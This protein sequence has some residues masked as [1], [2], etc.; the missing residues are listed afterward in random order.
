[1]RGDKIGLVGPNG[2]G[3]TTLAKIITDAEKFQN[4][5]KKFGHMVEMEYYSQHQADTMELNKTVYEI[6]ENTASGDVRKYLRSIL[7]S[8]LFKDDD[9]NKKVNVLS[10]GEKSRLALARMLLKSSNFIILDEPT[11]HLDMNS[12]EI[13]MEALRKYD[14][15]LLIISHDRE[16]LDGVVN[17]IMEIKNKKLIIYN[18]NLSEYLRKK[19]EEINQTV[20]QKINQQTEDVKLS[21]KEKKRKEAEFRNKMYS[22]Q[23]PLK[24]KLSKTEKNIKLRENKLKEIESDMMQPDFYKDPDNIIKANKNIKIIKDDLEA[25]YA[26]W[27]ELNEKIISTQSFV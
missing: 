16:F 1:M 17:K 24:D 22:I 13:L 19:E 4:G 7:G 5:E 25:L 6:L 3:K 26:E 20:P 12:K 2:T 15:S 14:G 9:V 11:N 23:K 10:G 18:G 27:M 8:F 21:N